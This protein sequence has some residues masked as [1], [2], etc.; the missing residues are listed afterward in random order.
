MPMGRLLADI[1]QRKSR[2]PQKHRRAWK[3]RHGTDSDSNYGFVATA[4]IAV[5]TQK[6]LDQPY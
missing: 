5:E 3:P 1:D 4:T 2:L 6:T